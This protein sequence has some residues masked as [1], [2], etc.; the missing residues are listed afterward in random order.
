[1][2]IRVHMHRCAYTNIHI[3][4]LVH[5]CTHTHT[6]THTH[7][8]RRKIMKAWLK[9]SVRFSLC[10]K[11]PR[12]HFGWLAL[13][14]ADSPSTCRVGLMS[15]IF[16]TDE[17]SGGPSFAKITWV[18][19]SWKKENDSLESHTHWRR[20]NSLVETGRACD[21]QQWKPLVCLL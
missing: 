12:W 21:L 14:L 18:S 3:H 9:E 8:G 2:H 15:W 4:T 1:M 13:C 7:M 5:S 17:C 10:L 19:P 6:H 16:Q 11:R 20:I